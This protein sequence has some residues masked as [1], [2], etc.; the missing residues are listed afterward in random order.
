[1]YNFGARLKAIRKKRRLT[2]KA[3]AERISKSVSAVSSYEIDTQIPPVEVLMSIASV[4]NVTLDYLVGFENDEIYT[5]SNLSPQ[6]KDL[7]RLMYQ[8][9][10]MP[11][12]TD[13]SNISPQQIEIIQKMLLYCFTVN[14]L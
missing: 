12:K 13:N 14:Q 6:Q 11:T 8:E 7:I 1:M 5:T 10:T 9:F 2:Q 3:L 4:L